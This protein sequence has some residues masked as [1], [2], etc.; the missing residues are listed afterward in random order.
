M[1]CGGTSSPG[2]TDAGASSLRGRCVGRPID[3]ARFDDVTSCVVQG[4]TWDTVGRTCTASG[5]SC[6]SK[7]MDT[8]GY[9]RDY[10]AHDCTQILGCVWETSTGGQQQNP[11]L[12]GTCTGAPAACTDQLYSGCF[13][14]AGCT[15][16]PTNK[17]C[18][19]SQANPSDTPTCE[20]FSVSKD[21]A[22]I[23]VHPTASIARCTA[24]KGCTFK[25]QDGTIVDG[26]LVKP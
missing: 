23:A 19:K 13:D 18:E 21:I 16:S 14:A 15:F 22:P 20:T 3:P 5:Q 8:P 24:M 25:R 7:T 10:G 12:G 17:R 2:G 9:F 11:N 4:E 26:D 1:G 6:E